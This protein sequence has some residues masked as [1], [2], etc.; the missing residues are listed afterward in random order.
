LTSET[1]TGTNPYAIGYT[2]DNAGN[3]ATKTAGG[4]TENY[5]YDDANKLLSAGAKT[6]AY[7][8]AG[9]VTGVTNG[10]NTTTLTWDGAN[11]LKTATTGAGTTTYTYNGAGQRVAKSGVAT[12]SYVLNDDAIDRP[13]LSDGSATYAHGSGLV[14]EARGGASKFYHADGLGTTRAVTDGAQG[15]TDSLE[16]DAFGTTVA[17]VGTTPTPFGPARSEVCQARNPDLLWC[18]P[19]STATWNRCANSSRA[20]WT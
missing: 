14:S 9:N 10:G 5:A 8:A 16:T 20:A 6:Y 12:A 3:R 18:R 19:Y 4:V 11:R 17:A 2:Y 1:R 7:D 13:V 15:V